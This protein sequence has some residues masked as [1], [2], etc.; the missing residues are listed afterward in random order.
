MTEKPYTDFYTHKKMSDGYLNKCKE[1]AKKDVKEK[2]L[3]YIKLLGY[4]VVE[5]ERI[6]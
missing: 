5:L 4:Q 3:D 2:Y 6:N 1:C